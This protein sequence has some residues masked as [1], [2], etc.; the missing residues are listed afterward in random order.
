MPIMTQDHKAIYT[1]VHP[2]TSVRGGH[3]LNW[4]KS[5][6]SGSRLL[7]SLPLFKRWRKS[8][9]SPISSLLC[10]TYSDNHAQICKQLY[11]DTSRLPQ[12]RMFRGT[13]KSSSYLFISERQLFFG[14]IDIIEP[15]LLIDCIPSSICAHGHSICQG[16]RSISVDGQ[17]TDTEGVHSIT[18]TGDPVLSSCLLVFHCSYNIA[19]GGQVTVYHAV[20]CPHGTETMRKHHNWKCRVLGIQ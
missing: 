7:M 1:Y 5:K 2:L 13:E 6:L 19:V 3:T 14:T 16:C 20:D 12:F 11:I 17:Q 10:F 9:A 4:L 15:L 8:R 18:H